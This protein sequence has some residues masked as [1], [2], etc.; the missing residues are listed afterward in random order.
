[1]NKF[2]HFLDNLA[3]FLKHQIWQFVSVIV[4]ILL[5]L[6]LQPSI[7]GRW[8]G[9]FLS[10]VT[11]FL[12]IYAYLNFHFQGAGPGSVVHKQR[13]VVI[14]GVIAIASL[15]LGTSVEVITSQL[16]SMSAR[17]SIATPISTPT[18]I[19]PQTPVATPSSL[20]PPVGWV[21]KADSP[22]NADTTGMQWDNSL[23]LSPSN[24]LCG[25][26]GGVYVA[27]SDQPNWCS[28]NT[29]LTTFALEVRMAI[30][31]GQEGGILLYLN[32]SRQTYYFFHITTNGYCIVARSDGLD[33]VTPPYAIDCHSALKTG[34]NQP[35]VIAV[36]A[37]GGNINL[38]VNRHGV[39]V[40]PNNVMNTPFGPSYQQGAVAF[41]V[42]SYTN[43]EQVPT[44]I[45]YSNLKLWQ[46]A[47][48]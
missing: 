43:G 32:S 35:N 46:P 44:E 22:L 9:V 45:H 23:T 13:I 36:L 24:G 19:P 42:N 48:T 12:L 29:N 11:L 21:L 16:P 39:M 47:I 30:V 2:T 10:I 28:S 33:K 38:Y 3:E 41:T 8:L 15:L 14:V 25:F 40:I 1:M 17:T 37:S 6:F 34:Q 7:F 18:T 5:V 4:S 26:K 27:Q 31:R 20:Y